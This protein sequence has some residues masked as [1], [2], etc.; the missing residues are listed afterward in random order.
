MIAWIRNALTRRRHAR[1]AQRW[2]DAE[3]PAFVERFHA[4]KRAMEIATLR[5]L[6]LQSEAADRAWYRQ[7]ERQRKADEEAG[8][9]GAHRPKAKREG[10]WLWSWKR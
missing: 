2:P 10:G 7:M 4:R 8:M 3:D 5:S 9:P 1:L 6:R